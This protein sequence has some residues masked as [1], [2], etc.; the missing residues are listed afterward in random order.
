M[1][2]GWQMTASSAGSVQGVVVQ[3]STKS[4]PAHSSRPSG[5]V[6]IS[7]RTKMAGLTSSPYSISASASAVWQWEHQCTGLE[8]CVMAPA[9]KIA[10][11]I[12]TSVAS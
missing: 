2:S 9:S 12:S 11:K 6:V 7:K 1:A 4:F 3:M 10:L 8:P 5:T